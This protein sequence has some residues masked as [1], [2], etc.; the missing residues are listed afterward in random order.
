MTSLHPLLQFGAPPDLVAWVALGIAA[1]AAIVVGA[2]SLRSRLRCVFERAPR[3]T[4]GTLTLL[5]VALSAGY[6]HFYLRGGPRIIDATAY[7][8]EARA[9]ASG[10][11]AFPV[12]AP[13]AAFRGRF[14]VVA[15][16]L[17]S[18]AGGA[19]DASLG[20]VGLGEAGAAASLGVL[21]PPGYPALL[22][23]GFL[24]GR[25]L[26]VG[27]LIGGALVCATYALAVRLSGRRDVGL[28]AGAASA[29][30]AALRYHTA[31]TMSHGWAALLLTVAL[32]AALGPRSSTG[33]PRWSLA[34]LLLAGACTGWLLAT[35]PLTGVVCA[36]ACAWAVLRATESPEPARE[37]SNARSR[38]LRLAA[39]S[40]AL[41]PGVLLLLAQQAT[42][43]GDPFGSVQL[44]YY[45]L[46]DG[47]PGCFG[48]GLGAG[49]G[50]LHE[51]G[52]VVARFGADGFDLGRALL[53]TLHR[54]HHH[55][56]DLAN[57]ELL[58][59]VVP[60]C[61]WRKRRE[62]AVRLGCAVA[63]GVIVAY[64]GFYFPGSF[65][66]GG[67][68]FFAE[69]LPFEHAL[70]AWGA[71]ELPWGRWLLPLTLLGFACHGSYSHRHLAEREGG[72]PF[73][74]PDEVKRA[75]GP[76]ARGA[77]LFVST[78]HGFNLGYD[79][80]LTLERHAT[81]S[82]IPAGR[83]LVARSTSDD[84]ERL[85]WERL[86]HPPAYR[87]HAPREGNGPQIEPLLFESPA[88]PHDA[89]PF[90]PTGH[91]SNDTEVQRF[92]AHRSEA[93]RSEA[94]RS[95][96]LRFET[97]HDWPPL[98]VTDGWVQPVFPPA[99]CTS[100]HRALTL[101]ATGPRSAFSA[102]LNTRT[103]GRH[104]LALGLSASPLPTA[105]SPTRTSGQLRIGGT[106]RPF[107]LPE[108]DSPCVRVDLGEVDL[109]AST[110]LLRV[111][112]GGQS[113]TVDY[114]EIMRLGSPASGP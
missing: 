109:P 16:E 94:Q 71:A 17:F 88:P 63:L 14:L 40:V 6:V 10:H 84:L 46:A 62:R 18:G 104:R 110:L 81:G 54:L 58:W 112:T 66:G 74:E 27:P 61:A 13:T 30:S 80:S 105:P 45:A 12:P 114:L 60:W 23:A 67:A 37:S 102:E 73:F 49:R 22:A 19:G 87:Y 42:L 57:L 8:L 107:D 56:L 36:G 41:L 91:T 93:H 11:F 98:E 82:R 65:P 85:L 28:L 1:G 111:E 64:G 101:H 100:G 43:T 90:E 51:H 34:R 2:P 5:A 35:R 39:F 86:G 24:V 77:L 99:P 15:Q 72:R 92:E 3:V 55:T 97:E 9:L 50:C 32:L 83:V 96:V 52:D 33:S 25:P 113:V 29:L 69:L 108:I 75:L 89:A 38:V 79:P 103:P 21:F 68:R 20:E 44:R 106:V 78:D 59:L 95:E 47:P 7:F 4:L 53:H 76:D 48:V 31:D 26:W 70:L